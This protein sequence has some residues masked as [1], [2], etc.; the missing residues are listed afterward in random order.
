M[1][2]SY[3]ADRRARNKGGEP[4]SASFFSVFQGIKQFPRLFM[5]LWAMLVIAELL[6]F[7][8][9]IVAMG[10]DFESAASVALADSVLSYLKWGCIAIAVSYITKK[11]VNTMVTQMSAFWALLKTMS[12]WM[13]MI[14]FL[15]L[16]IALVASIFVPAELN[17]GFEL[18]K[19]A[20]TALA[21][22]AAVIFYGSLPYAAVMYHQYVLNAVLISRQKRTRGP[23]PNSDSGFVNGFKVPWVALRDTFRTPSRFIVVGVMLLCTGA[24]SYLIVTGSPW[25]GAVLDSAQGVLFAILMTSMLHH[26]RN[27]ERILSYE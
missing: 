13:I 24:S 19:Q 25:I 2:H 7:N 9:R 27:A 16:S 18:S 1:N 17:E 23:R 3:L 4:T 14:C 15:L 20:S 10:E 12:I 22:A 6:S 21:I 8:F 11:T 26:S 5:S